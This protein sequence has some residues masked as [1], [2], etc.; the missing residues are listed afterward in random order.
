VA[1]ILLTFCGL[2]VAGLYGCGQQALIGTSVRPQ[3]APSLEE[4]AVD[5]T[6][7]K[8]AESEEAE[9]AVEAAGAEI[10][11]EPWYGD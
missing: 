11:Y 7:A 3:I 10:N 8:V 9:T 5:A 2:V 6:E 4:S 1:K